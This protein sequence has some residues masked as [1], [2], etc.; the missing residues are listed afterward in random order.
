[1]GSTNS[2][3]AEGAVPKPESCQCYPVVLPA[4]FSPFLPFPFPFWPGYRGEDTGEKETH[5]LVKPTAVHTKAP[6]NV[7][8]LVGISKL[9]L[10]ETLGETTSSALSLKL[11]GGPD[12]QSAFHANPSAG[13]SNVNSANNPIHAV[14]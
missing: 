7:E 6:I 14:Y 8:E 3:D 2:N 12:R 1:M 4:Y 9:S 13:S 5:E 11:D 10:G